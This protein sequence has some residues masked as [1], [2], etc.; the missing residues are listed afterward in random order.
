VKLRR[1]PL[2]LKQTASIISIVPNTG[3]GTG[4]ETVRISLTRVRATPTVTIGGSAATVTGGSYGLNGYVD[5][6]TPSGTVGVAVVSVTDY[7]GSTTDDTGFTYT[8][9]GALVAGTATASAG[10]NTVAL[11]ATAASGGTAPYTYQWY[12]STT[13]GVK[14]SALSGATS[15]A[16]DDNTAVNGTPYYYTLDATDAAAATVSYTQKTATP[17]SFVAPNITSTDIESGTSG[18]FL[19]SAGSN[20]GNAQIV[21]MADPT[22]AFGGNVARMRYVS[23]AGDGQVD[24]NVKLT[25]NH[26]AGFSFGTTFFLR[27]HVYIPTPASDMLNGQRKL[28]YLQTQSNGPDAFI[29]LKAEPAI[30]G[31]QS[32][33]LEF[34]K[35]PSGNLAPGCGS[36][37]FNTKTSIELQV[38][39]N[40]AA[41]VGDGIV[42][43]WIDGAL[44]YEKL[45]ACPMRTA[46]KGPFRK[47]CV[48]D[49]CQASLAADIFFDEYRYWDNLAVSTTRIGPG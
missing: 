49:Q 41:G 29:F 20:T 33:K 5:V 45:D 46:S 4:G 28:F 47:F 18:S 22:G 3:T 26:A 8:S 23:G 24:V 34:P 1:P 37:L 31:G 9:S 15:R 2:L 35:L 40:S 30:S 19:T 48:G 36:I 10:S 38:T 11:T 16:H 12:R 42:R 44:T 39:V 17:G 27:G 7:H 25:Y 32:L 14:G 21:L 6:T 13:S 43:V